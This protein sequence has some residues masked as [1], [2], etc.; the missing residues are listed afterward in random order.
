MIKDDTKISIIIARFITKVRSVCEL[1]KIRS[2]NV[3]C[4]KNPTLLPLGVNSCIL[5]KSVFFQF[6]Y[7]VI[8]FS[9]IKKKT[10]KNVNIFSYANFASLKSYVYKN[11]NY[12]NFTSRLGRPYIAIYSQG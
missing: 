1:Y 10:E 9:S 7:F 4:G 8:N 11:N 3:I 5:S 2:K 12:T 6:I